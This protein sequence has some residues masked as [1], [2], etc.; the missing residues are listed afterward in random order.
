LRVM[1]WPEARFVAGCFF[2]LR[3]LLCVA[4]LVL[5][6]RSLVRVG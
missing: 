1:L 2:P 5:S 4:T 3:Y 6:G